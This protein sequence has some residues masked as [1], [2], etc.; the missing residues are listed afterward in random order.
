M[1]RSRLV[2]ILFF[3]AFMSV[4]FVYHM[5]YE[6]DDSSHWI[7]YGVTAP[8]REIQFIILTFWLIFAVAVYEPRGN[9]QS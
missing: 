9:T 4:T 8:A 2:H 6:P 7:V 1:K 3:L 5:A